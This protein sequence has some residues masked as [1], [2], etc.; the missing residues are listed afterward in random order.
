[1]KTTSCKEAVEMDL[2]IGVAK[3][4]LGVTDALKVMEVIDTGGIKLLNMHARRWTTTL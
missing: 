4:P 1:L 2:A 3:R